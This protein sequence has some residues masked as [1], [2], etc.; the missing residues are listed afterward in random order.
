[1]LRISLS[2]APVRTYRIPYTVRLRASLLPR[3]TS[4]YTISK[5]DKEGKL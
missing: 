2:E 5:I 1:M 3:T 4:A